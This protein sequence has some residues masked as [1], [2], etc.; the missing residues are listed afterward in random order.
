L[1]F[2]ELV[3]YQLPPNHP[4]NNTGAQGFHEKKMVSLQQAPGPFS[5]HAE[6][7]LGQMEDE[8]EDVKIITW[9][10][11]MSLARM[12]LLAGMLD[13]LELNPS[14]NLEVVSLSSRHGI[15]VQIVVLNL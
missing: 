14:F 1:G 12:A 7:L 11:I 2:R 13:R 3:F 6:L 4:R 5:Q 10:S 8:S 15:F 9:S